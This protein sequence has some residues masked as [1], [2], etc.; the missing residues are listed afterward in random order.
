[1]ILSNFYTTSPLLYEKHEHKLAPFLIN[2]NRT[3]IS[4]QL[5]DFLFKDEYTYIFNLIFISCF[6][7]STGGHLCWQQNLHTKIKKNKELIFNTYNRIFFTYTSNNKS[8]LNFRVQSL[9]S[10]V[11]LYLFFLLQLNYY[12]FYLKNKYSNSLMSYSTKLY[13][14]LMFTGRFINLSSI[15]TK[16]QI[17][18]NTK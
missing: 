11:K 7:F 6:F 12:T 15:A 4:M 3:K 16:L 17:V 2:T 1:M 5:N 9:V 8:F 10:T 14:N 13:A 18:I